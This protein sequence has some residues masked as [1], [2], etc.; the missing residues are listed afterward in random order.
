[1]L[2]VLPNGQVVSYEPFRSAP[3][4][5]VIPFNN[6]DYNGGPVMPSNTD[7]MLM[8]S[9]QGLGAYPDG[10]VFGIS[11][12]FTDLAHDS[13]ESERRLGRAAVQRPD[14]R[15]R[16]LRRE[17]GGVLV[18]TDPYPASQCPVNSPV[19][20]CLTDAQIQQEIATSSPLATC[21]RI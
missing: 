1:M 7:Y 10:F 8:W 15:G 11:R 6:M 19:T 16:E 5:P 17:F 18:D 20:N 14:R 13:G 12:Y 21:R 9:P 3:S 2:K 4:A